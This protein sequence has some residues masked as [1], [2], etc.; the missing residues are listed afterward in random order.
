MTIMEKLKIKG[1]EVVKERIARIL[2]EG[3]T[4]MWIRDHSRIISGEIQ[5]LQKLEIISEED[6]AVLREEAHQTIEAFKKKRD[7]ALLSPNKK[8]T[9][10][11]DGVLF[12]KESADGNSIEVGFV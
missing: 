11:S 12:T 8:P 5:M 2:V 7:E 1:L 4:K 3:D 10:T 9:V 6:A